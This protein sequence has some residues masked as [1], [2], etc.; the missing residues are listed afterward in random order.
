MSILRKRQHKE[1]AV[2]FVPSLMFLVEV[3]LCLPKNIFLI[4][5]KLSVNKAI[6]QTHKIIPT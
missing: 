3:S 1:F 6:S 5:N 4:T 2:T